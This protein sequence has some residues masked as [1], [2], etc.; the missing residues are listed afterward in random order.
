MQSLNCW[1]STLRNNSRHRLRAAV[2]DTMGRSSDMA[3]KDQMHAVEDAQVVHRGRETSVSRKRYCCRGHE[4]LF[5]PNLE[6]TGGHE[7]EALPLLVLLMF[8]F[9]LWFVTCRNIRDQYL[10]TCVCAR[11]RVCVRVHVW[12]L[13][14]L[15]MVVCLHT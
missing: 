8:I 6:D 1:V 12:V 7:A 11:V 13:V 2:W 4:S 3:F 9:V 10:Q 15:S 14:C 5:A